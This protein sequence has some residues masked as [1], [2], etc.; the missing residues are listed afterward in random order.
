MVTEFLKNAGAGLLPGL[1]VYVIFRGVFRVFCKNSR[2]RVPVIHELG[3][4]L[5]TLWILLLGSAEGSALWG[6]AYAIP[7]FLMPFL[8]RQERNPVRTVLLGGAT[9]LFWELLRLILRKEAF[10]PGLVALAL[11]GAFLGFVLYA[12]FCALVRG[13][14]RM[15]V[16]RARKKRRLP[17]LIRQELL[18]LLLLLAVTGAVQGGV[19]HVMQ[20]KEEKAR[21]E[22][23]AAEKAAAEQ[24]A[25][26]AAKKAEEER[27]AEEAARQLQTAESMPELSLE[28]GAAILFSVDDDLILYEKAGT[29]AEKPASTT[30]LMTALT[31]LHYCSIDEKLTAGEEIN[32]VSGR[33]ST[34]SLKVGTTGTVET[35]LGAM[36][37]PS[38]NDAAYALAVHT[39]RKILGNEEAPVADAVEA[40]VGAMKDLGTEL[41]LE[42]SNFTTPD[43]DQADNQY[44]CARDLIRI[45]RACLRDETIMKFC[46][47][48]SYRALFDNLDLT[49]KNTNELIQASGEYY[50]EGA[51]GMKT[52]SFKDM[53]CLVAAVEKDGKTWLAVLLDDK[54]PGRYT[55]A[56]TLFDYATGVSGDG[57]E[58]TP[59]EE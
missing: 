55:D 37:V 30:K 12:L 46:G 51:V 47:A 52:G 18:A 44:S 48:K 58:D 50:Y 8:F 40:F 27:L 14:E 33:A 59:T 21:Q 19:Q 54:D 15:G 29:D 6:L 9:A 16:V 38:G 57:G 7:G 41:N 36:L 34:A 20:V 24:A 13:A 53:K 31:V 1:L 5:L 10:R 43:G 32:L 39:G 4:L 26:E 28:A 17:G 56:K 3:E 2:V 22:Q 45:A 11:P 42:N 35:F 25:A 23:E 49:Y